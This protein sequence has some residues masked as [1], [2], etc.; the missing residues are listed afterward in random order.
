MEK[1]DGLATGQGNVFVK[2]FRIMKLSVFLILLT[3]FQAIAINGASQKRINLDLKDESLIS[4]LK[5]LERKY[6][7]R[8]FYSDDVALDR[9]RVDVYASNATIDN[10]MQQLLQNTAY[11]YKTMS[12][13]LVVII[14]HEDKAAMIYPVKGKIVNDKGEPLSGVTVIEKGT[15]NGTST[16][17][18]GSFSIEVK[19]QDAILIISNVGYTTLELSVKD[20][21]YTNIV[22][23]A[24]EN[25]M[26]E[27]VVVG[28]G[29]QKKGN[30]IG[31]ISQ[32]TS[33]D[34]NNRAVTQ[35]SQ[36]L[37]GQMPG[38][39]V[40]QRSGQPGAASSGTIRIR[41]VASFGASPD[42]LVLVDGMPGNLNNIDPN[43]IASISVLKDAASAAIYG[44]RAANG[45]ILVTT[46][47]GQSQNGKIKIAYNGYVGTQ[48]ATA[49]P[50]FVHS[51]EYAQAVNE[52]TPGTYTAEQIQKFKDG[53]DPDNYPDVNYVDLLFKKGTLQTG[54][55]LSVANKTENTDYV[56]SLGYMY[57][58]GIVPNNDY[59]RY[60]V[61]LNMTNKLAKNLTLSTRLAAIQELNHQPAPSATQDFND[62]LT[63]I[64]QVVRIPAIYPY[65]LSN[66]DLGTGLANKGTPY[67]Y[68]NNESFFRSKWTN[69]QGNARL[70]WKIIRG[71]TASLIA[72][73]TNN[74]LWDQRFLSTQ[75]LNANITLGPGNLTQN[76]E[77]VEYKTIQELL[78]Y[79]RSFGKHNVG[80]LLGHTYEYNGSRTSS[81]FRNGYKSNS[82]TEIDAGDPSTQTNTGTKTEWALDS[83]FGRL[84]YDFASKYL[85]EATVRRDGSSRFPPSMRYANFPGVAVGWR[86]SQEPF[87]KENIGVINELKI[88]ASYGTLGNQNIGDYPWQLVLVSIKD[89]NNINN[90]FNYPFG[91]AITP[92]AMLNTLTD[93]TLHWESTRTK[94]IA[95]EG[96]ALKN[97]ITFS[98]AYFDRY[99]YDIL[100]NPNSSYSNVL[101]FGVGTVNAGRLSNKGWEFELGFRDM[102]GEFSY[103]INANFSIIENK[104]LDLGPGLNVDQ[105]NGLMGNGLDRFLG[106]PLNLYYGYRT[107]GL[108]VDQADIDAYA[109]QTAINAKPKPGDI[110]YKDISGPDGKP[111]G[112]V[113]ANYDRVVLGTNIPKYTYGL[114]LNAAY[115]ELDFSILLQGIGGAKGLLNRFAGFALNESGNV[116]RW[117]YEDRWT[118]DNPDRNAKYPRMEQV[119]NTG[120]ANTL[121]SDF[122]L[123]KGNYMRIKNI[124]MGYTLSRQKLNWL[125][126]ESA[127]V[128]ISA[129]NLAT[130]SKYP[131]GWDPEIITNGNYYPILANYTFGVNIN[132]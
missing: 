26:D 40:I 122:W 91:N 94:D 33:K 120:S 82:L 46:K 67:S 89:P 119:S 110:R 55:N 95:L 16:K 90:N 66:G 73:Y 127:R 12:R 99:G 114:S 21:N 35:A 109:N 118:V 123:R 62:M 48:R 28:Y 17:G 87:F 36:A 106:Y 20:D 78:E 131:Q 3:S 4:I 86:I 76:N 44:S 85:A 115:S 9:Q 93:A 24:V 100:A 125:K 80:V 43:D 32:I 97:R 41:G 2:F 31:A 23:A 34:I 51:W 6:E 88:R 98:A 8:F 52:A 72:G 29:T 104:V 129:E 42:A 49:Y 83:Y 126:I 59:Q 113:D 18:D 68:L 112:K 38:I 57:Q 101:G 84:Q 1:S 132:F 65:K 117:Q 27:V 30:V 75:R 71:L 47:S 96:A 19:D 111:D 13:D 5:R 63:V 130:F 108:F 15:T 54:H 61:R 22:M 56:L 124:Q 39:T 45:V 69:L 77:L 92:G 128:F 25:K 105:P 37:T 107:D 79:K 64:G 81:A 50:E 116:Q 121:I 14:G 60:N 74:S 11:S 10:V 53:S 58:N 7:Y 70:D 103:G 102:I